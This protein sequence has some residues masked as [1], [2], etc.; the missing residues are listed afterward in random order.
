V[1]VHEGAAHLDEKPYEDL[2][3]SAIVVDLEGAP[4]RILRPEDHLRIL[5]VHFLHHGAWRPA[6]LCDIALMIENVD[7][8]FDWDRCLT[9][10]RKR[11]RW[12][13]CTIELANH[14]LG[15]NIDKVPSEIRHEAMPRW[16]EPAVLKEWENPVSIEHVV[17]PPLAERLQHP[18][19]TVKAIR[20]RWPPNPIQATVVL[21]GPFNDWP[22][23]IFQ[24]GNYL[25]RSVTFFT[26]F[27]NGKQ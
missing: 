14:L 6:G 9:G 3:A 7:S 2:F 27:V 25:S 24:T 18:L 5:V 26:K 23:I 4:V 10:D 15:A 11:A 13:T 20:G 1:D 8:K 21:N 19:E 12:I 16:L 17:P 22:R